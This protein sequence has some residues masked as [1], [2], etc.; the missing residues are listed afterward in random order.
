MLLKNDDTEEGSPVKIAALTDNELVG[1]QGG[2]KIILTDLLE[3]AK[4]KIIEMMQT[5]KDR[6]NKN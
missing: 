3:K 5:K 2:M 1:A 4:K 6:R